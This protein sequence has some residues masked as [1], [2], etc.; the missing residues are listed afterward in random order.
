MEDNL[1]SWVFGAAG[2]WKSSQAGHVFPNQMCLRFCKM[3]GNLLILVFGAAGKWNSSQAL[4]FVSN[5]DTLNQYWQS[6]VTMI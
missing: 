5:F 1:L 3:D 4:H 2:N 6:A